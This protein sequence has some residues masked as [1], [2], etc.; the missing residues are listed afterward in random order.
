MASGI[1]SETHTGGKQQ[2]PALS[3]RRKLSAAISP[4]GSLGTCGVSEATPQAQT[5][6]V[7]TVFVHSRIPLYLLTFSAD[8][9]LPSDSD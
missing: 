9:T 8:S 2:Y 3:K 7:S 4:P 1:F 5:S 6:V